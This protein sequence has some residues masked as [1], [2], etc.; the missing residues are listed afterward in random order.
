MQKDH[1]VSQQMSA[2]KSK[3]CQQILLFLDSTYHGH[4]F[5]AKHLRYTE[6]GVE[7]YVG[8]DIHHRHQ[9]DRDSNCFRE[10]P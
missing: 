5:W 1:T 10:V 3:L 9:D 6:R 2:I 4:S 8:Q 7:G